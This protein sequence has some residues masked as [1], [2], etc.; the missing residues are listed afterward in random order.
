MQTLATL[1]LGTIHCWIRW[2]VSVHGTLKLANAFPQVHR[3]SVGFTYIRHPRR[4]TR[5]R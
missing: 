1:P 3:F 4:Q 5:R 2:T